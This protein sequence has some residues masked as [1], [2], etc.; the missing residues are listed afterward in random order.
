MKNILR[1]LVVVAFITVLT[2]CGDE[3]GGYGEDVDFK[4]IFD[5]ETGEILSLG[6]SPERFQEA[7]GAPDDVIDDDDCDYS[8]THIYEGHALTV[9]FFDNEAIIISY[10]ADIC[11]RFEFQNM[12][13]DVAEIDEA[14]IFENIY[15]HDRFYNEN[16]D[17][18]V[19]GSVSYVVSKQVNIDTGEALSLLIYSVDWEP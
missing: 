5:T 12:R 3:G 16:G 8:L 1:L 10:S 15:F 14:G 18:V 11:T 4:S 13:F 9:Y 19:G 6:D 17:E 2:A 7:L